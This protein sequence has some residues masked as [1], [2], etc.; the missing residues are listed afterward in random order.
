[1]DTSFFLT[2][3]SRVSNPG[4]RKLL[5]LLFF[6]IYFY[7]IFFYIQMLFYTIM[8]IFITLLENVNKSRTCAGSLS[9][10]RLILNDKLLLNPS[11][12]RPE[13]HQRK[14]LFAQ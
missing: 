12:S 9:L 1:M 3:K 7:F 10:K 2:K 14:I 11:T 6:F 13:S 8:N 4:R 5:L